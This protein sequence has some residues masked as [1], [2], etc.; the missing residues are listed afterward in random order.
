MD[1]CFVSAEVK[2]NY[3]ESYT[4][5]LDTLLASCSVLAKYTNSTK[6]TVSLLPQEREN[7]METRYELPELQ[8]KC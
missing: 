1:P 3:L 7:Q 5:S 6:D 2:K 4:V 8:S